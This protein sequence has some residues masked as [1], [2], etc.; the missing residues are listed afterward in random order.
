MDA[1][2]CL[3]HVGADGHVN[4]VINSMLC[5]KPRSPLGRL[6]QV[7]TFMEAPTSTAVELMQKH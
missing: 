2:R 6:R 1:N 4:E 7:I 3:A 5:F